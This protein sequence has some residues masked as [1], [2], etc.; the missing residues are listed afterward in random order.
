MVIVRNM[1]KSAKRKKEFDELKQITLKRDKK[2]PAIS[3]FKCP[4][5]K[6]VKSVTDDDILKK[7]G[8]KLIRCDG[9]NCNKLYEIKEEKYEL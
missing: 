2:S 5:C 7:R 6:T 1:S 4:L 8:M 9:K 3:I